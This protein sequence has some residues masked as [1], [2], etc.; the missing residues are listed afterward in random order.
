MQNQAADDD[1]RKGITWFHGIAHPRAEAESV[2]LNYSLAALEESGRNLV[3]KPL[4]G[5]HEGESA[6]SVVHT[7]IGDDRKLHAI[8]KVEGDSFETTLM[9]VQLERGLANALSLNQPSLVNLDTGGIRP[10]R[11]PLDL[12]VVH[13]KD[14]ARGPECIIDAWAQW[15]EVEAL[16]AA[17]KSG[18]IL[19]REGET[20]SNQINSAKRKLAEIVWKLEMEKTAATTPVTA[21]PAAPA[22]AVVPPPPPQVAPPAAAAPAVVAAPVQPEAA[23]PAPKLEDPYKALELSVE[24]MK[25]Q[26]AT[27]ETLT[28][29]AAE[30]EA[31][32]KEA[33]A[34]GAPSA[35]SVKDRA[36][37]ACK[38]FHTHC[39]K[40]FKGKEVPE[41]IKQAL[42]SMDKYQTMA[43]PDLV[44]RL[45][46]IEVACACSA[47]GAAFAEEAVKFGEENKR[48]R[49]ENDGMKRKIFSDFEAEIRTVSAVKKEMAAQVGDF[50][51][52]V[53]AVPPPKRQRA[54]AA[55]A[56]AAASTMSPSDAAIS[57]VDSEL[58]TLLGL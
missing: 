9:Q 31:K 28:K 39:E 19:P 11:E 51:S 15:P 21:Q 34:S 44:T 20:G 3:G 6:G 27:I 18:D 53:E 41:A 12:G 52:R 47:Q 17:K 37:A 55:P 45:P 2:G 43:E 10:I 16:T 29:R 5:Y 36:V 35:P 38:A 42:A 46:E 22:P 8:G 33:A 25:D 1:G 23:K 7:Y 49:E 54:E 4:R 48:L 56:A 14:A 32:L 58:R 24:K 57:R 40:M 50:T 26:R 13:V 30:L